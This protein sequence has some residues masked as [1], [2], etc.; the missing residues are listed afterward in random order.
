MT[1]AIQG[2]DPRT[3]ALV[4]D[5][6]PATDEA[7]LESI[8][9]AAAAAATTFGRSTPDVRAGLL[10]A[11]A[12]AVDDDADELVALA[13]DES[14]LPEPRLTGEVARTT[15]QLRLFADVVVDGGYL[16]V[17]VDPADPTGVPPRPDLRRWLEPLGPVL[18]FAASNFPFAFS[19]LGGDTASA[20]AAGCPVVVKAHSSHP[21]LS[22]KVAAIATQVVAQQ[23][24][25]AGVFSAVFGDDA[26]LSALSDSRVRAAGFTGSTGGGRFLFDVASRRPDPIPFYGELGSINPAVV[27]P[28]AAAARGAEIAR[29]FV[30][31]VTLGTGQFCTKP[32]LLF[33]PAGHAMTAALSEAVAGSHAAPMLNERIRSQLVRGRANLSTHA[34]VATIAAAADAPP[35]TGSWASGVVFGTNASAFRRDP[36]VLAAEYFGPNSLV[37]EYRD[38]DELMTALAGIEGTLTATVQAEPD[39]PFPVVDVVAAL[40]GKAGRL[41][42]NGWPTGVAVSWAMQHGGPWPAT[43]SAGFTSVGATA[44]RRW[45]RPVCYQDVPESLLPPALRSDNPWRLPRRVDGRLTVAD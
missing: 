3:G 11:L 32:G 4:G 7:R 1:T 45:V 14:G 44:I 9:G 5:A 36:D 39:D 24:L 26:G 13:I 41:V 18:V 42:Y 12:D 23:G 33:L 40:S 25:P 6:V 19:V 16:E 2:I 15:G 38:A 34:D 31:S 37:V 21:G 29:G 27:T 10:R 30:A 20:L 8:L 35:A 43:T 17:I 28:A 22:A